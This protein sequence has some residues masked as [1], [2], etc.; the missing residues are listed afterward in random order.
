MRGIKLKIFLA[1]I[2][3]SILIAALIGFESISHSTNVAETNSREKLTL[4]CQNKTIELNSQIA[5]IEES[6]NTLSEIVLENLD[7]VNKFSSDPQ[8]VQNYQNRIENIARKF[9]ENT[10]GAMTFYIRFNPQIT[11]PTSGIF[12]SKT[13][14]KS[15]FEKLTPTDFSKYDPSDTAHVGWY[16]IPVNAK[17]PTW[18]DPYLNSNI[19]VYMVSY[20]VPLFKD[21]KSIGIVGMDID[22]RNIQ[23]IVENTKVYDSGYAFLVNGKYDIMYH[24]EL[25]VNDNLSTIENNALKG[26]TDEMSK[27][28]SSEAQY[29]YKYKG[30]SK[31]ISYS[32]LSNGWIFAL[33]APSTEIL[34]Q[35]NELIKTI[36]IFIIIGLILST[37]VAFY[38]GNV[39]SKPIIKI[40]SIIKKAEK[41]DLTY[42]KGFDYLLNQKSEIG[43]LSNAFNNMRN[44][45]V[46]F[47]KQILER[48]QHISIGSENLSETVKELTRKAEDIEKAVNNITSDVQETSAASEQISAS[49]QEVDSNINILSNK[50]LEGSNSANNSKER[51][52]KVKSNGI[53]SI[54][55]TRKLYSEKQKRALKAIEDGKI[56]DNIKVMADTISNISEQTNLL[57]LNAAIEAARAGEQ[58]KGFAVVAEEV[59]K[60]AEQSSQAVANIKDTI[61]KVQEAF[62]NLSENSKDVLLFIKEN[63][64][65]QFEAMKVTGDQYYKDAEFVTIMS[66][67]IASMTE[68]LTAT[69]NQISDA[70][71]NTAGIAQKSSENTEAIKENIDETAKAIDQVSETAKKQAE[72]AEEFNKMVNR[73]NV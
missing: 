28:S 42:D 15:N 38:I 63:V 49:I 26:L 67:E 10:D 24:P 39:I 56:V 27:N 47:I 22:F 34:K 5:K 21:G 57:A 13:D 9:G 60:L 62:K 31:S 33:T 12:Y 70:I 23:S 64:D 59:R 48:S 46:I 53:I 71:Q 69:I 3:C 20:V 17:K 30:I 68:E 6:V 14:E 66:E 61:I 45:F 18:L 55:E 1:I 29:S 19:N 50:A 7:D 32:H 73:F 16:Y 37:L 8:Y 51:A 54:E 11:P 2:T 44:E 65:P 25:K 52:I 4:M 35:S 58:G 72:L 36:S 40:T 43:E 41:L